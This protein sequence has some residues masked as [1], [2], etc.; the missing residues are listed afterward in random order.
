MEKVADVSTDNASTRA[1]YN[2]DNAPL[3]NINDAPA[4]LKDT[5]NQS[6]QEDMKEG[7]FI[8]IV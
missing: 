3:D 7:A 4:N 2:I 8:E 1:A 6:L 5:R